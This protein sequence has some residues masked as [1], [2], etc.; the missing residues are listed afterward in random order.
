MDPVPLSCDS[1]RMALPTPD[2][3]D[4]SFLCSRAGLMVSIISLRV[5]LFFSPRR[6]FWRT[7][8]SKTDGCGVV[9]VEIGVGLETSLQPSPLLR[10]GTQGPSREHHLRIAPLGCPTFLLFPKS[11]FPGTAQCNCSYFCF[12]S[13]NL[14]LVLLP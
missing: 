3:L 2:T 1:C 9:L 12:L 14:I 11:S 5:K 6:V 8:I 4:V 13:N 10:E 7:P